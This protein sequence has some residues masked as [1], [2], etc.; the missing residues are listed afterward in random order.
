MD[1]SDWSPW[2]IKLKKIIEGMELGDTGNVRVDLVEI[3]AKS[4]I[5]EI[6]MCET[7]K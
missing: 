6:S 7:L 3:M 5:I 1:S 4:Y 2:I